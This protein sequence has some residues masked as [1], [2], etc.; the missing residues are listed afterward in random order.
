MAWKNASA[1]HASLYAAR[2]RRRQRSTLALTANSIREDAS[3]GSVV[4]L[5]FVEN[6]RKDLPWTFAISVDD[7]MKFDIANG[8]ELQ[9]D[10]T[11]DYATSAEHTVTVEADNGVDTTLYATFKIR[12]I[13]V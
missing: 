11:L 6:G 4:G 2:D 9:L 1:L 13:E 8:N 5:L 3:V 7:D 12:V 10:D